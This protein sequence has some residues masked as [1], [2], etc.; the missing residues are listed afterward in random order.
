MR[1][2]TY[3]SFRCLRTMVPG[4]RRVWGAAVN[5]LTQEPIAMVR[6]ALPFA[7]FITCLPLWTECVRRADYPPTWL[8]ASPQHLAQ[9]L[10]LR[11]HSTVVC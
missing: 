4:W 7:P 5:F 9:C 2:N 8:V 10:T 1:K 6:G 11:R 3:P